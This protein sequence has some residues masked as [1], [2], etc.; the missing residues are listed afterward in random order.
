MKELADKAHE[1]AL[2]MIDPEA[3]GKQDMKEVAKQSFLLAE[4]MRL[5]LDF[6]E[7][8]QIKKE[9]DA[10]SII[11]GGMTKIDKSYVFE[12]VDWSQAPR[13]ADWWAMDLDLHQA[14]WF[15]EEPKARAISWERTSRD[16]RKAPSFKYHGNWED[17]LTK[18]PSAH[19]ILK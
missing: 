8:L 1:Y 19:D 10:M 6:R 12:G 18:R 2:K 7:R 5:E 16:C 11:V 14:H 17:S 4:A 3:V 13:W 15:S 9:V